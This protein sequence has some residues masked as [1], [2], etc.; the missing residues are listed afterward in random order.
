MNQEYKPVVQVQD[1]YQLGIVV[2]DLKKSIQLYKEL[3]GI[4]EWDEMTLPSDLFT[5]LIYNGKQV[6]KACFLTGTAMAGPM[7]I[8]LI[9]PVE[10]DLP[11]SDFLKEHG[12]GLH[13]VGHIYVP[14]MVKAVSDFEA[15][16]FPCVFAGDAGV[17]FAYVDMTKS[18]GVIIELIEAPEE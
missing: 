16:G 6:E 10:G 9:Q 12:E 13:H 3:L 5:S 11:Y 1:L 2:R 7:Q 14:D 15:R 18:L 8:E 17:K 4:S